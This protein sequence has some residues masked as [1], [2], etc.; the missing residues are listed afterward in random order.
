MSHEIRLQAVPAD[1]PLLQEF[2]DGKLHTDYVQ[3][4]FHLFDYMRRGFAGEALFKLESDQEYVAV[5]RRAMQMLGQQPHLL[6]AYNELSSHYQFAIYGLEQLA[7]TIRQQEIAHAA[8]LGFTRMTPTADGSQGFP[9]NWSTPQEANE[10]YDFLSQFDAHQFV[11]GLESAGLPDPPL[12][13]QHQ[14]THDSQW[15]VRT[16]HSFGVLKKFYKIARAS[17]LAVIALRD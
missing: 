10:V 1:W 13:K 3:S 9:L 14:H 15:P 16:R 17:N 7:T 8:V 11:A 2:L 5:C 12:Y 6:C 4:I